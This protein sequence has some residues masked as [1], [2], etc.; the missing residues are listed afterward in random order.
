MK[1]IDMVNVA[2]IGGLLLTIGGT[3]IGSWVG[4]KETESTLQKLV[5]ERLKEKK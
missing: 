5:D 1:K 4:K 3:I 2:R